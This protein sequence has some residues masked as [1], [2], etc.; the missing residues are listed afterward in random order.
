M[1]NYDFISKQLVDRVSAEIPA[2][3]AVR[4]AIPKIFA[5]VGAL[6]DD[7]AKIR[8]DP[9]LSPAGAQNKASEVLRQRIVAFNDHAAVIRQQ[10]NKF[11]SLKKA[12]EHN[13]NKRATDVMQ[14]LE[15]QE[16]RRFVASLPEADRFKFVHS[17]IDD[18]RFCEAILAAPFAEA[19]GLSPEHFNRVREQYAEKHYAKEN[20]E[21]EASR[22]AVENGDAALQV[23][24]LELKNASG[25]EKAAFQLIVKSRKYIDPNSL[26]PQEFATERDERRARMDAFVA[27]EAWA[28]KAMY[29]DPD[30]FMWPNVE[31]QT[32][33]SQAA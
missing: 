30:E 28:V 26:S 31:N 16:T 20:A 13:L 4:D 19:A 15:Q 32:L 12:L 3:A 22:N 25:L 21:L 9:N 6:A 10:R 14:L 1:N 23:A 27:S 24:M 5:V 33:N 8:K 7:A 29:D 18:R 11:D 17:R 2:G